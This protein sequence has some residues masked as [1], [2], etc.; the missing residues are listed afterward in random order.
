M[1]P[2]STMTVCKHY[3]V[4]AS[5]KNRKISFRSD[6]FKLFYII[7]NV[8]GNTI[9]FSDKVILVVHSCGNLR[10]SKIH[11]TQTQIGNIGKLV[12]K[13]RT[14]TTL[15]GGFYRIINLCRSHDVMVQ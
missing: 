3:T 12:R 6:W 11:I 5:G 13:D 14:L 10:C 15:F 1:L 7:F 4:H 8:I 2:F 9:I